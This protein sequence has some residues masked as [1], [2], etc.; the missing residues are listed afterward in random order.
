MTV[1]DVP[2]VMA[3]E[4]ASFPLPWSSRAFL[5][6]IERNTASTMLVVRFGPRRGSQWLRTLGHPG[7]TKKGS[8]LG[9]GGFWL[10]VDDIHISTVAVHP[11]WRNRGLGELLLLS[12]LERGLD[13]DAQAITLEVRVSNVAAQS[14]YGKYGFVISSRRRRYYSDNDEDAYIMAI[15]GFG[16]PDHR[17]VLSQQRQRLLC[18][19]LSQPGPSPPLR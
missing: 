16:M 19:M 14:L 2:D 13:L 8:V 15:S 17:E 6:E 9:Y 10:L 3:I 18:T 4:V 1:A 7:A 11:H 5:Y 12:L